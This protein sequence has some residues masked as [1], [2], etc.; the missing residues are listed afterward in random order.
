MR[1]GN[2]VGVDTCYGPEN[3]GVG[4]L[5]PVGGVENFHFYISSRSALRPTYPPIQLAP[6]DLYNFTVAH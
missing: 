5:V 1:G 2:A 3:R 4:V 6:R